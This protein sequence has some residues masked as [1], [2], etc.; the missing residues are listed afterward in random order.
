MNILLKCQK[1]AQNRCLQQPVKPSV[2]LEC[3]RIW[4]RPKIF[5]LLMKQGARRYL[6]FATMA[7]LSPYKDTK[8]LIEILILT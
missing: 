5:L 1:W 4:K 2:S 7:D 6:V 3:N 8:F